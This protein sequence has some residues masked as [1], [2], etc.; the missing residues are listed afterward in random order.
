MNDYIKKIHSIISD[1]KISIKEEGL[2]ALKGVKDE[3]EINK[4]KLASIHYEVMLSGILLYE[5]RIEEEIADRAKLSTNSGVKIVLDKDPVNREELSSDTY[6]YEGDIGAFVSDN[7]PVIIK[8][9]SGKKIVLDEDPVSIINKTG[10]KIELDEDPKFKKKGSVIV[11]NEDPVSIKT[12]SGKKIILDEDPVSNKITSNK[13]IVLNE[14][15]E[16]KG[17]R[18]GKVLKLEEDPEFSLKTNNKIELDE[19]PINL[20]IEDEESSDNEIKI[21]FD[22]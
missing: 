6:A 18:M 20:S 17:K 3:E 2:K 15:P 7:D 10:K 19:D 14:D 5:K 12:V 1:A 11:L 9:K 4:I 21:S 8:T 16:F 13:I 22:E